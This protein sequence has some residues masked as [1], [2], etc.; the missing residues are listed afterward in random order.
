M[1][2]TF[3]WHQEKAI[4]NLK[5]HH[6]S[7]EEAKTIFNDPYAITLFDAQHSQEENRYIDIG[8]S[9]QERLLVVVYSEQ[10]SHIRIISSRNVTQGFMNKNTDNLENI[11]IL[12]E[13]DF[14]QGVRGKH[15]QAYRQGHT[16]KI[17]ELDGS[18]TM[19]HFKL[20][21]GAVILESDVQK[22]FPDSKSVNDALRFL[23][24][25]RNFVKLT[26]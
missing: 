17:H 23:I 22:Y 11:D 2:L 5:K 19:Q 14:S 6:V 18:I 9:S 4:N 25:A 3:E 20:E 10:N 16:V 26:S 12:P 21:E 15:Y 1:T 8:Y 13:Y 24:N 7:F